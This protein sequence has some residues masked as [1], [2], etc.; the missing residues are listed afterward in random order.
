MNKF[1]LLVGVS[2][3]AA[4]LPV[5]R[6]ARTNGQVLER[7]LR[8]TNAGF[9][10][11][12]VYDV[13]QMELAESIERFFRQREADD[14]LLFLFSGYG[15]RDVDGQLY[16]VTPE[17][18]LDARGNLIRA[19]TLPAQFLLNVMNSSAARRQVIIFDC[20]FQ[21]PGGL[22]PDADESLMEDVFDSM[23]D[24]RRVIL[25]SDTYT[26]HAQEPPSLDAWSYTR[27]LAEGAA[28]GA[29][30]TNCDGSLTVKEL[31]YYACR[32][33]RIAAPAQHPQFYGSENPANQVVLSVPSQTPT[34]QYRQYLEKLAQTSEIDHTEFRILTG[35]NRMNLLRQHLGL[36][37]QE[38]NDIEA[39]VLRPERE[40]QQRKQLYQEAV[41][42]L[43]RGQE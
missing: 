31:H 11:E 4:G 16:L 2:R 25:V 43:T 10:V 7:S 15:L 21:V 33:L 17:T 26:R 38:A 12:T 39:E 9:Q 34:V 1:A 36:S 23:I 18:T 28:T 37:P 19:R 40:Y 27:Y 20:W 30:D 3:C 6:K 22:P 41:S 13:P 42:R 29:A 8:T 35:R 32:K 5:F 14:Q 24:D